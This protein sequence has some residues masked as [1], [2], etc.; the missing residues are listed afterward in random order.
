MYKNSDQGIRKAATIIFPTKLYVIIRQ[1]FLFF[2]DSDQKIPL[3][4][5]R[6][7]KVVPLR[8]Q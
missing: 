7:W 8:K 6:Q 5:E 3:S 4:A 1:T 2:M